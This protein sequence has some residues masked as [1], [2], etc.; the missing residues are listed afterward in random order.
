M[1]LAGAGQRVEDGFRHELDRRD[2][3]EED[4]DGR[5]V[6]FIEH[7]IEKFADENGAR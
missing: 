2:V 4:D 1:A 3:G 7:R 5:I 6:A